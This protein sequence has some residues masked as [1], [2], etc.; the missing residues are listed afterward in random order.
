MT[1]FN[2]KKP[3]EQPIK[4]IIKVMWF[5]NDWTMKTGFGKVTEYICKG[6]VKDPRFKVIH[7]SE[8][9]GGPPYQRDGVDVVG[10]L[11]DKWV[12]TSVEHMNYFKPDFFVTLE[13]TFTLDKYQFW[14]INFEGIKYV[15]YC[16][17]DGP[18]IPTGGERVLRKADHIIS[19]AKFTQDCLKNEGFES[20][21]IW[22]GVDTNLFKPVTEEQQIKLKEK[23]GY[24]K[25]DFIIFNYARN[26][27]RKRNNRMLEACADVCKNNPNIKCLFHIQAYKLI[28][29]DLEDFIKRHMYK[30]HKIDFLKNGQMKFTEGTENYNMTIPENQVVEWLQMFK[31]KHKNLY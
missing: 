7:I 12:E 14:K 30:K 23:Y 3:I 29:G 21:M 10:V 27:M 22:H 11:P 31:R 16:P 19:M 18:W 8:N 4:N 25:D 28:D 2:I 5:S 9:Y 20:E 6:L 17:L 24:K 13:D 15:N 26:S 1:E